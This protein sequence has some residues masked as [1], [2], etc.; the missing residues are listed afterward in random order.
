V[1]FAHGPQISPGRPG[2]VSAGGSLACRLW[3]SP[4]S[5]CGVADL[6]WPASAWP[7]CFVIHLHPCIFFS[8]WSDQHIYFFAH[9]FVCGRQAIA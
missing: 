4:S 3:P 9:A 2:A 8:C 7:V 5:R 6:L 1:N